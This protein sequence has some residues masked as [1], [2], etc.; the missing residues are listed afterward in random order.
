MANVN[1]SGTV[2]AHGEKP[3]KFNGLHF[4]RWQQKM[5]FYL[6]T[7]NLAQFLTET[8]PELT[9]EDKDDQAKIA[10][11][12]AWNSSDYLCR[13]YLMNGLADSL[14]NVYINTES[15]KELWESLEKKL[16][17]RMP[18]PRNLSWAA[19]LIIRWWIP[20]L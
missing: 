13:N 19:S 18:A 1:N 9:E 8:A 12:S 15:A 17:L 16:R 10:M 20:K 3:E 2:P 4:K 11:V 14:Y 6:T 5:L 7:L